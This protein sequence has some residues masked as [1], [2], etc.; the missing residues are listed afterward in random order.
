MRVFS[1]F[2]A[3]MRAV[4]LPEPLFT[5]LLP[6]MDDLDEL[7]VTLHV[8][9]RLGEQEGAVRYVRHRDLLADD[10]L[11]SGL[12]SPAALEAALAR[13]VERGTLLLAEVTMEG[14]TERIYL[15]NT[16]RGRAAFDALRRGEPLPDALTP[17]RPNIFTLY[18]Q[19]IGPL[20]PLIADALAEA[21]GTYPAGWI[22][23]AFSE[24]VALNRRNWK[25]IRA[26]LERW[27]SEGRK[28]ETDRRSR[29]RDRR[30]YIEGKYGDYIEH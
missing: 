2:P 27:R 22:E 9:Y 8:L 12:A 19:N 18:E 4:R 28:D 24:A 17:P 5:V 11:L 15:P 20:T 13:A 10:L 26:I 30:R 14:Q 16:P 3:G 23:E 25:Y 29:E 6:D 21:E 7:K 1:G